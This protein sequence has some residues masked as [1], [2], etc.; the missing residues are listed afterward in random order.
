MLNT[1]SYTLSS[2]KKKIQ[3]QKPTI[4][5]K[6]LKSVLERLVQDEINYGNICSN[7]EQEISKLFEI[8][9]TCSLSSLHAAYHLALLSLNIQ[10]NDEVILSSFAP[11]AAMDTILYLKGKPIIVDVDRQK[12]ITS[13]EQIINQIT[14][15]TKA[16]IL[17]YHFGAFYDYSSLYETLREK[18]LH[19]KIFIIEDIS[20]VISRSYLQTPFSNKAHYKIISF[21]EDMPIT[22]GKGSMLVTD[23]L[24]LYT[25][26]KDLL[27]QSNI[28]RDYKYRFDY[29]IVDYQ[30]AIALEQVKNLDN[31]IERRKKI[32]NIYLENL[33]NSKFKTYFHTFGMDIYSFFPIISDKKAEDVVRYFKNF[34]I[35]VKML[36][37][38]IEFKTLLTSSKEPINKNYINTNHL[39]SNAVCL[40]LYPYLSKADID[41]IVIALKKF[42]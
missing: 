12:F 3:F 38:F 22:M 9:Y 8:K 11:T 35:E 34:N 33:Q 15:N 25:I 21:H 13:T 30:A 42:Y 39:I 32:A 10:N 36:S 16:I 27:I 41:Y 1:A 7:L 37:S 17:S 24:N 18:N 4:T 31:L 29:S 14:E 23:S 20:Q 26:V 28:Q 6:E 2:S 40:P 19:Q 5:S